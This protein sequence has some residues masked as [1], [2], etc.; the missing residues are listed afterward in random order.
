MASVKVAI[1]IEQETLERVDQLVAQNIFP[2]RSLAIQTAVAE[3]FG[4]LKR[5]RL[6]VECAN[7]DPDF[8]KALAEEGL[9]QEL[10]ACLYL[11]E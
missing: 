8:E 5:N 3:Q 6:A 7:L 11:T 1:T 9:G 4:R 10:D 2:N